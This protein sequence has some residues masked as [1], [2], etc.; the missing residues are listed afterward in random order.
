MTE[1]TGAMNIIIKDA[2][3]PIMP[4][5]GA[6]VY[7]AQT[8]ITQYPV[9]YYRG[10]TNGVGTLMI[11]N[12]AIGTH[13]YAA[14]K[15]GYNSARG[16]AVITGTGITNV[17]IAMTRVL[18]AESS[19]GDLYITSTPSGA[20]VNVDRNIAIDSL[21]NIARTPVQIV[22]IS[23]GIHNIEVSLDGYEYGNMSIDARSNQVNN[24][25]IVLTPK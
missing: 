1:G 17:N 20:C 25:D 2:L 15:T 16:S 19:T 18:S 3:N 10:Y 14:S 8:G 12:L 24:V 5:V 13:L 7:T 4:V 21:G 6:T 22:G 11:P 23:E 9:W